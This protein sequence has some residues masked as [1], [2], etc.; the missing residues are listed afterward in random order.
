[1]PAGSFVAIADG[2]IV[3]YAGLI[4]WNGDETLAEN[5]LT[6]VDGAWRGRGLGTALKRRQMAWAA[7]NGIREI[8]TWTQQGNEAMQ[9][10]NARLGY[11]TRSVSRTMHRDLP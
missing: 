5:G 1:M 10:V 7:A 9:H 8:V 4:A 6:V 11:T 3:G 2:R